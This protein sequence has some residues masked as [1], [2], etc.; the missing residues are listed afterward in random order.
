M[1]A[2][3]V[4]ILAAILVGVIAVVVL[5]LFVAPWLVWAGLAFG[6]MAVLVGPRRRRARQR[7]LQRLGI[8]RWQDVWWTTPTPEPASPPQAPPPVPPAPESPPDPLARL[9]LGARVMVEQIRHKAT[10][11]LQHADR[12]PLGSKDLF[13][14]RRTTEE[15]LP[16]TLDAYL[17][18]SPD[19]DDRPVAPDGRTGLQVLRDQLR[20]LDAKLD[21]IAEDLQRQNVDRLLANERFLEEH[22]GHPVHGDGRE[23]S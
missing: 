11:L 4:A 1:M 13:V 6:L 21:E 9:P 20:L 22:F 2:V 5:S 16:A 18:L 19:C 3:T 8:D 10:L 17:A 15:Y 12:F 23:R 14:L 7:R